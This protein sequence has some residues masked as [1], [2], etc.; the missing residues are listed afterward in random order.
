MTEIEDIKKWEMISF[1]P[2]AMGFY[3]C[4]V[5]LPKQQVTNWESQLWKGHEDAATYEPRGTQFVT[6]QFLRLGKRKDST[7]NLLTCAYLD[8]WN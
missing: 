6:G 5:K 2:G 1:F 3:L 7:S 4:F 8:D